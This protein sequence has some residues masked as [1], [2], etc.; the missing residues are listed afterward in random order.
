MLKYPLKLH[1]GCLWKSA[2]PCER[3]HVVC[4]PIA[5][6]ERNG[7]T[8][9]R[10]GLLVRTE[11][12]VDP[13]ETHLGRDVVRILSEDRQ[14]LF[15]GILRSVQILIGLS[16]P[17][18]R[19][20]VRWS[21]GHGRFEAAPGADL[22]EVRPR[23]WYCGRECSAATTSGSA[24]LSPR[25]GRLPTG[26]IRTCLSA[27]RASAHRAHIESHEPAKAG[28]DRVS[29]CAEEQQPRSAPRTGNGVYSPGQRADRDRE[30]QQIEAPLDPLK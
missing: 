3:Q 21:Q 30:P 7:P 22:P 26:T 25:R 1:D 16:Q 8:T 15:L 2:V 23:Q 14:E 5:R 13:G 19:L 17:Q 20:G 10:N 12:P 28:R 18:A 29:P 4:V 11:F 6:S 24:T 27:A 9:G